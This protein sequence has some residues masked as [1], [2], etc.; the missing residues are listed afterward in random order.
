MP[1]RLDDLREQ[2]AILT[3]ELGI[4]KDR[5]EICNLLSRY[6][7]ALDRHDVEEL[8]KLFW[9]D[10][11]VNYGTIGSVSGAE[12]PDWANQINAQFGHHHQHHITSQTIELN[13]NTAHAETYVIPMFR[14]GERTISTPGRYFDRLERRNG[15]WRIL[16]REW[17]PAIAY[18]TGDLFND[19]TFVEQSMPP[20]GRASWDRTD[21]SYRRPLERR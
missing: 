17:I 1:A 6:T 20:H 12:F 4:L 5:A 21:I 7:R 10:G 11:Q 8:H 16:V 9:P 15:E 18:T 13:G 14:N 3:R 19:E 2:V